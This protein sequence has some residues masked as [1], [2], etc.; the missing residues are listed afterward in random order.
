MNSSK[1]TSSNQRQTQAERKE[2]TR[3]KII[4]SASQLFGSLGFENTSID[5]IA[6]D[7]GMTEGAIYHHYGNKLKLFL[8]VTEHQELM[9]VQRIIDLGEIKETNGLLQIWAEFLDAC[10]QKEFVQI[11]LVDSPHVLGR[12][13]WKETTVMKQVEG[14]ILSSP[15]MLHMQLSELDKQLLIR[16]LTTALAEAALTIAK[17]PDYDANL[18]L[19][20]VIQF[21]MS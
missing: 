17:N 16:M 4:Q 15:L 21:I 3:K 10:N 9:L 19:N 20:K 5:H 14:L 11:V 13:R 12:E 6:S 1:K 8:A 2:T 7:T 18:L